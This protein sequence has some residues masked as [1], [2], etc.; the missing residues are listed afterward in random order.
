MIEAYAATLVGVALA[1][2]SPGP[3]MLA[4]AGAAL[5]S[6][7][8][9]ALWTV[10]GVACGMLVWAA[11]VAF[12]LGA[13]LALYPTLLTGMKIVGGAYL[14]WLA[15][16]GLR[17]AFRGGAPTV[18]ADARARGPLGAWRRGLLVV[19]TNPK[20]LLMWSAVGTYLFGSGLTAGQVLGFGPVGAVS[21]L[22]IYGGYGLLFSTGAAAGVYRRFTR[23]IEAGM[24][25]AFGA[26]GGRL[27]LDG[28]RELR[29]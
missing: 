15:F 10:G 20:A 8:R 3:N 25:V 11:A 24:G 28:A 16:K 22:L 6:G 17:A 27:I 12:G 7:R 4:V 2:A 23:P 29:T 21:A 1:Q 5:G 9:A 18:R 26:L 14:A 19:L 13:V